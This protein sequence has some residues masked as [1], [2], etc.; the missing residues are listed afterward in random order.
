MYSYINISNAKKGNNIIISK[1]SLLLTK[2]ANHDFC[3]LKHN[4]ENE[5][6]HMLLLTE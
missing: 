3:F 6:Y 4:W 5:Y 1:K 2:K